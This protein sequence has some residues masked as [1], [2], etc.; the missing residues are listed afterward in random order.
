M[1]MYE[2][3]LYNGS[4]EKKEHVRS[5]Q[6]SIA[7]TKAF[8]NPPRLQD[9]IEISSTGP[10]NTKSQGALRVLL[11]I[12][13]DMLRR[14]FNYDKRELDLIGRDIRG[15]R[16]YT[17]D[18]I[19]PRRTGGGEF[20][21]IRNEFLFVTEGEVDVWCED[22]WGSEVSFSLTK[23]KG[24]FIPPFILHT[25][26]ARTNACLLVVANTLFDASD[27]PSHDTYPYEV[28]SALRKQQMAEAH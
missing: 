14:F 7:H 13:P 28:F 27:S 1:N 3:F 17:V 12:A 18:G 16:L 5:P 4:D 22:T 19:G 9:V 8:G 11:G 6:E 23:E 24:L 20:H 21:R 15:L 10:W 25:Y 2:A 26:V